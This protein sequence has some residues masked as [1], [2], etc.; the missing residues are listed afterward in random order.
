[1]RHTDKT[2]ESRT[3]AVPVQKR[4]L[5]RPEISPEFHVHTT[6]LRFL[7]DALPLL[8]SKRGVT[9]RSSLKEIA[10]VIGKDQYGVRLSFRGAHDQ[11]Y[12]FSLEEI[13]EAENLMDE[14]DDGGG[15]KDEEEEETST[16]APA[17]DPEADTVVEPVLPGENVEHTVTIPK[18]S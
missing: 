9:C 8:L 1:M 4:L 18:S 5:A 17:S 16:P 15:E 14:E 3:P 6:K 11:T 10:V 13:L 2:Q 12:S 7:M